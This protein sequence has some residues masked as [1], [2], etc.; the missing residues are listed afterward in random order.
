M[1]HAIG[2]SHPVDIRARL[3]EVVDHCEDFLDAR[4]S[5]IA[6]SHL[7]GPRYIDASGTSTPPDVLPPELSL[8]VLFPLV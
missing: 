6:L 3:E 8:T 5:S 7:I 2:N 1:A 4:A